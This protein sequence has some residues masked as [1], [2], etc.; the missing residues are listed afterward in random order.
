MATQAQAKEKPGKT[1]QLAGKLMQGAAMIP[2]G[3]AAAVL[4]TSFG[5]T[6]GETLH[7]PVGILT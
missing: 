1:H 3:L 4:D 2:K 7:P 6:G 5:C